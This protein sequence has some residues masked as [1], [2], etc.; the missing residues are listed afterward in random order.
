MKVFIASVSLPSVSEPTL[1]P[2]HG[3]QGIGMAEHDSV[4][5][6]GLQQLLM[7]KGP[8]IDLDRA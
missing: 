8:R 3:K 7:A 6:A 5:A 2:D 1:Q 4:S